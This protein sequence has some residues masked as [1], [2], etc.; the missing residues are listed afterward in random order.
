MLDINDATLIGKVTHAF[1][2]TGSGFDALTLL[3]ESGGKKFKVKASGDKTKF[4]NENEYVDKEVMIL[5]RLKL[6]EYFNKKANKKVSEFVIDAT[7]AKI[8]I[9]ENAT[10]ED[11]TFARV[12][13]KAIAIKGDGMV[14]ACAYLGGKPGNREFKERK[15]L[16]SLSRMKGSDAKIPDLKVGH[17]Y[18]V[19]GSLASTEKGASLMAKKVINAFSKSLK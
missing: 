7:P 2:Y 3:V 6:N 1:K 8:S 4:F 9:L 18:L 17:N 19:V 5:G 15:V 10:D 16:V 14:L 12:G 13:G 11:L